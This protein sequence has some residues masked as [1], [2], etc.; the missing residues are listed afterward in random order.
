M[1]V[2]P[3]PAFLLWTQLA[4]EG[5]R[6]IQQV[7]IP[8]LTNILYSNLSALGVCLNRTRTSAQLNHVLLSVRHVQVNYLQAQTHHQDVI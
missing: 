6:S 5:P 7:V 3:S 4:S 8:A 2:L 1:T